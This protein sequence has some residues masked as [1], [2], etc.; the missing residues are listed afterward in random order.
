MD[1]KIRDQW[2]DNIVDTKKAL[3]SE[4]QIHILMEIATHEII[5]IQFRIVTHRRRFSRKI[6]REK[7]D[8]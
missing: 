2:N 1:R 7:S 4:I 3:I 8:L 6:N 5:M